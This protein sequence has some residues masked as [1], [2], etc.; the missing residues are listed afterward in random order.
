[1]PRRE[2]FEIYLI[3]NLTRLFLLSEGE[4]EPIFAR[5]KRGRKLC[6]SRRCPL[7]TY[8]SN[9]R[10]RLLPR[11]VCAGTVQFQIITESQ[12]PIAS[13]D[14]S[15]DTLADCN[16]CRRIGPTF[17]QKIKPGRDEVACCRADV[18]RLCC[19]V[20]DRYRACETPN[21]NRTRMPRVRWAWPGLMIDRQIRYLCLQP[22]Q[23]SF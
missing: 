15:R 20:G 18:L 8:P 14:R 22:T 6:K 23:L 4:G 2:M 1:M 10:R 16:R 9:R 5:A 3:T 11:S 17:L 7:F 21:R 13:L 19:D 12:T